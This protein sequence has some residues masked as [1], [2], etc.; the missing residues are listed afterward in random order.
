MDR[1]NATFRIG[2]AP[3][4]HDSFALD[5][6]SHSLQ[7]FTRASFLFSTFPSCA[8]GVACGCDILWRI[9]TK[10]RSTNNVPYSNLPCSVYSESVDTV[11][12]N[13]AANETVV[14]NDDIVWL[15]T[16]G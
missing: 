7:G 2:H 9:P 16:Q 5:P 14:A 1:Q 11:V 8:S 6:L 15:C 3:S 4:R 10:A 13:N 12:Q